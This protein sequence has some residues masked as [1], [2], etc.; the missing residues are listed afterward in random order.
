MSQPTPRH[1][2]RRAQGG[3]PTTPR[4]GAL[5]SLCPRTVPEFWEATRALPRERQEIPALGT[6]PL[7]G[8]SPVERATVRVRPLALDEVP[9]GNSIAHEAAFRLALAAHQGWL[10]YASGW[11]LALY[12]EMVFWGSHP[13]LKAQRGWDVLETLDRLDLAEVRLS[14][15]PLLTAPNRFRQMRI[16]ERVH[17]LREAVAPCLAI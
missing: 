13:S 5:A 17:E 11:A 3:E 6:S 1:Q 10:P 2:H 12:F 7:L 16:S 15:E 4:G 9:L 8:L 14:G